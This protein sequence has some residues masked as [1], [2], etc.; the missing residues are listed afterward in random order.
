[1]VEKKNKNYK[2]GEKYPQP[3]S[4]VVSFV[5]F[6]YIHLYNMMFHCT[7]AFKYSKTIHIYERRPDNIQLSYR[8]VMF[9]T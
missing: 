7:S 8:L 3:D 6:F 4:R 1:M 9:F 5:M 2:K